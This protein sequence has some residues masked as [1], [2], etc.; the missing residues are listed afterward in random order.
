M[1]STLGWL[2]NLPT[3]FQFS[4]VVLIFGILCWLI[5]ICS[6]GLA[7]SVNSLLTFLGSIAGLT[8]GHGAVTRWGKADGAKDLMGDA[9]K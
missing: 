4:L 8:L 3:E 5:S 2:R 9:G 6:T 7:A 1:N